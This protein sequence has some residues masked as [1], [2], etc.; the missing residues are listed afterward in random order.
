MWFSVG[1]RDEPSYT[2]GTTHLDFVQIEE[3]QNLG[4]PNN[5]SPF[6][7]LTPDIAPK[8]VNR[9]GLVN[10]IQAREIAAIL[11]HPDEEDT[12]AI[13]PQG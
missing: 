3:A 1:V 7:E 2:R 5:E 13:L 9:L 11:G 10:K 8:K 4:G 12:C 6:S